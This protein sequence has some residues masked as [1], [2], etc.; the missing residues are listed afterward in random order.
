MPS[1]MKCWLTLPPNDSLGL[2]ILGRV[3]T[4]LEELSKT[5]WRQPETAGRCA[6]SPYRPPLEFRASG[7]S[8]LGFEFRIC[9]GG[10]VLLTATSVHLRHGT[11]VMFRTVPRL[12]AVITRLFSEQ[13]YVFWPADATSN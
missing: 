9:D 4:A 11:R 6:N 5:E 12:Y 2:V 3:F 10:T 7:W 8:G 1:N 13:G